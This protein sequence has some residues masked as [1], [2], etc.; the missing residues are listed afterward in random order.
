[1][2]TVMLSSLPRRK[3]KSRNL[4]AALDASYH[5]QQEIEDDDNTDQEEK[6]T[7]EEKVLPE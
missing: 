5:H 4:R 7:F 2:Q 6:L 3:A 1:M